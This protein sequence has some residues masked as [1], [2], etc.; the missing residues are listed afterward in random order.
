MDISESNRRGSELYQ[1]DPALLNTIW[2]RLV[3]FPGSET[4][5]LV[6]RDYETERLLLPTFF[7]R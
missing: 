5:A 4:S 1:P 2:K 6:S 7:S 3:V